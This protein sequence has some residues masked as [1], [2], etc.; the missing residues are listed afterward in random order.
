[1]PCA[2]PSCK[3]SSLPRRP[4]A[5]FGTIPLL[6]KLLKFVG[7]VPRRVKEGQRVPHPLCTLRTAVHDEF[8]MLPTTRR[9]AK[10]GSNYQLI[11]SNGVIGTVYLGIDI[12]EYSTISPRD[13]TIQPT[14]STEAGRQEGEETC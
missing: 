2:I 11:G 8:L 4:Q 7:E 9:G 5:F 10:I 12:G 6:E 14:Q 1:M 3:E 13:P